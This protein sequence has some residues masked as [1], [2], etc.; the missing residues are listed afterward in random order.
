MQNK[1]TGFLIGLAA[2]GVYLY[3][4]SRAASGLQIASSAVSNFRRSG[5]QFSFNITFQ[6]VNNSEQNLTLNGLGGFLMLN[7]QQIGVVQSNKQVTIAKFA[8]T[9]YVVPV[10]FQLPNAITLVKEIIDFVSNKQPLR[11]QFTGQGRTLF[12][13]FPLSNTVT[14]NNPF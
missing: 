10:S 9:P 11:M 3:Q 13:N 6:L 14:I 8:T 4:K 12:L 5:W 1:G 2:F 7:G